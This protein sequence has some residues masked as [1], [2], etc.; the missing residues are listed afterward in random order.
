[1]KRIEQRQFENGD[2]GVACVAMVTGNSYEEVE[3]AFHENGIVRD[4][5]YFSFHK[6]LICVL[7][8]MGYVVKK[9]R[10]SSW[11]EVIT[12]SIVK[13]N[14]RS[15]NYWHWVVLAEQRVLL[16]PKPDSPD[17]VTHYRGRRGSG[18]YLHILGKA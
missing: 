4:G 1:M 8:K 3:Q 6:D 11:K 9:R 7:E 14:V 12:P 17:I 15:G 16:D 13:I 10:F 18:E 2:C 5:E